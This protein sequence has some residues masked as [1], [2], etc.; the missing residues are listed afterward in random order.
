MIIVWTRKKSLGRRSISKSFDTNEL[1]TLTD[2][3]PLWLIR[4]SK[5]LTYIRVSVGERNCRMTLVYKQ[6]LYGNERKPYEEFPRSTDRLTYAKESRIKRVTY[7]GSRCHIVTLP[8]PP[9]SSVKYIPF[10]W[11]CVYTC[12]FVKEKSNRIKIIH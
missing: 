6:W 5:E 10:P 3:N 12:V 7:W 8:V 1:K 4:L 11:K 2:K 9:V